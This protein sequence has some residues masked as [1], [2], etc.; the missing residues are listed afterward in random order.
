MEGTVLNW[1]DS[2]KK[3]STCVKLQARKHKSENL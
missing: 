2:L 1:P 3:M